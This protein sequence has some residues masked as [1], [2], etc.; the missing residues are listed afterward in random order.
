MESA[1]E[2]EP[3]EVDP[4]EE[5]LTLAAL[6][7]RHTTAL[8]WS[9]ARELIAKGWVEVGGEIVTDPT[10]RL[11]AGES[12]VR[13]EKSSRIESRRASLVHEDTHLVVVDKPTGI[14]SVPFT[15]GER[16]T[17]MD[18]VR[19]EWRRRGLPPEARALY[20]VHRL[21][22]ETS[23]LIVYAR[24]RA[25]ERSIQGLFRA[26]AVDRRYL[27]VAHGRVDD[28]RIET[29][30][31]PDRGD[32]IRGSVRGSRPG[33]KGKIAVTWVTVRERLEGATLLE[34]RLETG[35]TH[36]IRIHLAEKGHPLVGERVYIRD[37][38]A[39]GAEPVESSRLLLHAAVLGLDHPFG[40]GRIALESPL[41]RDFLVELSKLRGRGQSFARS[42][43]LSR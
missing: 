35:R 14:S 12:V 42:D 16:G 8:S 19:S 23:G 6:L 7:R 1:S 32:G 30:L 4:E 18:V 27:A 24:T 17:L 40:G 26:H 11:R 34:V 25:A 20:V 43:I 10:R 3:F 38:V 13:R 37:F 39:R 22:R 29:V 41:P 33:V 15:R 28:C 2:S 5:G 31:V 21:D 9:R 36:Q